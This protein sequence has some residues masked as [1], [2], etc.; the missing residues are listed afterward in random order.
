MVEAMAMKVPV[1][2]SDVDGFKEVVSNQETGFIVDRHNIEGC[3][4][5]LE[6]LILNEDLRIQMGTAG[7]KRAEFFFDWGKNVDTMVKIYYDMTEAKNVSV[8]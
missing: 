8:Y 5:A 4:L 6:K 2:V 7:R 1:V 3:K